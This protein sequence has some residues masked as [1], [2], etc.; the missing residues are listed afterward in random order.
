MAK[1]VDPD[2]LN[3]KQEIHINPGT[4]G[5]IR[6]NPSVTGNLDREDGVTGQ[7]VYSFLKEEWRT[8]AELIRYP[9]PMI[10]ITEEQFE[11]TNDWNWD[12]RTT[13]RSIRDA[14]WALKS[15]G[16]DSKQEWMN[17][18]TLGSF[19]DG[20]NDR[21][22]YVNTTPVSSAT[23]SGFFFVGEVNEPVQIFAVAGHEGGPVPG[24]L[25]G[26]GAAPGY[27]RRG[28][29]IAY[30]RE[31]TKTFDRYDLITEQGL[32]TLTYK[33]YALPL[34]STSDS[35]A[36]ATDA[37]IEGTPGTYG[38]VTVCYFPQA[39]YVKTIGGTDYN[40]QVVING[41]QQSTEVIY[42]KIQWLLRQDFNINGYGVPKSQTAVFGK[43]LETSAAYP[44]RGDVA[45]E[46]LAFVGDTLYTQYQEAWPD[47][48]GGGVYIENFNNDDIN[49]LQFA[50]NTYGSTETYVFFPYTATGNLL[51]N[52]NLVNDA[53]AQYWMFFTAIGTSAYGTSDAILVKDT[54]SQR[55]SGSVD[56]ASIPF[57]FDYDENEQPYY[58]DGG[59]NDGNPHPNGR[60]KG[61][62]AAVTVVA[63][64]L[65]TAQFVSTT[66]TITRSTGNNISLVAA[67][68]RNYS[69]PA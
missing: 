69:N 55:I 13:A 5:T 44:I 16:G 54:N 8:D 45:E 32:S 56:A 27:D 60:T 31:A 52:D 3:Q 25:G 39:P 63:I 15:G 57:T 9:F 48:T 65:S 7:C 24:A 35:K 62:N 28:N 14:G 23:P 18:T 4:S 68:E 58:P 59:G 36:D 33:K 61:T 6:L 22:Y 34:Q 20:A 40:F 41:D 46:L 53:F 2:S 12:D 67:L 49:D 11:L 51:F 10:A 38:H 21:A 64:G 29:F 1:L 19:A 66:A 17:I 43:S 42:E 26:P 47:A 30:L 37:T 50:D